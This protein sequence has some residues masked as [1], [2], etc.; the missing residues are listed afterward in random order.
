MANT[1]YYILSDQ[2]DGAS[3]LMNGTYSG[4]ILDEGIV[5]Q[6]KKL[7]E[8]VLLSVSHWVL[9]LHFN[10]FVAN[11][12]ATDDC[13]HRRVIDSLRSIPKVKY[14]NAAISDNPTINSSYAEDNWKFLLSVVIIRAWSLESE[15]FAAGGFRICHPL[16]YD[17]HQQKALGL[18]LNNSDVKSAIN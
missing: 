17:R 5:N 11:D 18:L 6:A 9:I 13:G 2:F 10:I 4:D 12:K 14:L 16:S 3:L 1:P 7:V 8:P 15:R